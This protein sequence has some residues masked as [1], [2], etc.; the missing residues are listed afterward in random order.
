MNRI[1]REIK[2]EIGLWPMVGAILMSSSVIGLISLPVTILP[3]LALIFLSFYNIKNRAVFDKMTLCLVIYIPISLL[4]VTGPDP[5]F[6]S[7]QRFV[8]FI[9]LMIAV[10]PLVN[11]PKAIYLKSRL[12]KGTLLCCV[13]IGTISFVCYFVGINYMR[14]AWDGSLLEYMNSQGGT[15]G[16]I[17]THS[18]I[19]GPISGA[20]AITCLYLVNRYHRKIFWIG[21]A[22]CS[23]SILFAA[24]RASLIATM[25]GVCIYFLFSRK[26]FSKNVKRIVGIIGVLVITFPLWDSALSGIESKNRELISEGINIDTRTEKW[27]MRINEWKESPIFGIGFCSVSKDDAIGLGGIIEPGSSWLAVLSMTGGIGFILFCMIY[28]RACKNSLRL[29]LNTGALFGGI[30]VMFGMHMIAEGYIYSAG[31]FLCYFAWLSIGCATEYKADQF[32]VKN[33]MAL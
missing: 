18:M 32:A 10:S 9:F 20:G 3:Y 30:V 24:S 23:G 15:F 14:S 27:E 26:G 5:I 7:W 16:G 31:S 28:F 19:L 21:A 33:K 4:V 17:T 11:N 29:H 13:F 2:K 25:V 1:I 22:M 6:K 8:L 12:F